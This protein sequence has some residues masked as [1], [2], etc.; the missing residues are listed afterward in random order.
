MKALI[1][2][3]A[4]VLLMLIPGCI[5]ISTLVKV[6][7]DGSGTVEETVFI[8]KEIIEMIS[9]LEKAFME[10][11][12]DYQ[13]F[14]FYNEDELRSQAKQFGDEVIYV[15]SRS[16]ER[17]D[18]EG[19]LVMYEYRDLNRLRINQNPNSRVKLESFEDEAE[20]EEEL[21]TFSYIKGT[22]NEIRIQMPAE[23]FVKDT[24][25][26]TAEVTES[27]VVQQDTSEMDEQIAKVFKDLRVSMWVDVEG[28]IT[29]TNAEYVKGSR[30]TLLDI[31]FGK[32]LENTDK[33]QEFREADPQNFEEVKA[34]LKNIPGVEV[35]LNEVITIQYQ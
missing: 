1:K 31:D 35:D 24:T 32:L 6:N 13:P 27:D 25:E 2:L 23:E 3:T 30:I 26:E 33:L 34:I 17:D 14:K 18:K 28:E 12:S 9:E 10:D 4:V 5:E 22:P 15:S 21:I 19:Y 16:I 11:T 20:V 7:K 29:K 8:S